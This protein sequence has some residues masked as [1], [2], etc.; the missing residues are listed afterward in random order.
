MGPVE[1]IRGSVSD[2]QADKEGAVSNV[3]AW[4]L[5]FSLGS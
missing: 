2:L 1:S 3:D 4:H 5:V